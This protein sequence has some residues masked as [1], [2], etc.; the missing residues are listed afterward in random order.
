M[1]FK[2]RRILKINYPSNKLL[3][4][5]FSKHQDSVK[6]LTFN[7]LICSD[8][9]CNFFFKE[10]QSWIVDTMHANPITFSSDELRSIFNKKI[11]NLIK[12]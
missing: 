12:K 8:E 10:G 4:N 1:Q 5:L 6:T 7:D 3:N 11:E 9:T 2:Q